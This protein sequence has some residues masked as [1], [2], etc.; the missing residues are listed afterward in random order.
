M[1]KP[2]CLDAC[3]SAVRVPARGS[4]SAPNSEMI[5]DRERPVGGVSWAKKPDSASG[6]DASA[7]HPRTVSSPG[8]RRQQPGRRDSSTSLARAVGDQRPT[9]RPDGT[10]TVQSKAPPT[11]EALGQ[12][13]PRD[14][15]LCGLRVTNAGERCSSNRASML[16]SSSPTRWALF[17][18]QRTRSS[19]TDR[20]RRTSRV[21]EYCR[22]ER[23]D[24]RTLRQARA[25]ARTPGTP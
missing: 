21:Q 14:R 23:A 12:P 18:D 9:T 19:A 24:A 7:V 5:V 1:S 2:R 15:V 25:R 8:A 22:I 17:R 13:R 4:S 16:S 11:P 3:A 6:P 20:G 10:S